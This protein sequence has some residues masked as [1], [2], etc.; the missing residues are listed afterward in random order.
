MPVVLWKKSRELWQGQWGKRG[1]ARE[2][3]PLSRQK[4][5]LRKHVQIIQRT[6]STGCEMLGKFGLWAT[7]ADS[8]ETFAA[9]TGAWLMASPSRQ[10]IKS[11]QPHKGG[12]A[13]R[14]CAVDSG[15]NQSQAAAC[16]SL[17]GDGDPD[18]SLVGQRNLTFLAHILI[19]I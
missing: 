11:K 14:R 15:I 12:S 10:I 17:A 7:F 3:P 5:W 9:R 2:P 19:S 1:W 18:G 4:F 8:H 6:F 13:G 16:S